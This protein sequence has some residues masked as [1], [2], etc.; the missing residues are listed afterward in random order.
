MAGNKSKSRFTAS[1]KGDTTQKDNGRGQSSTIDTSSNYYSN[2]RAGTNLINT[3]ASTSL[4]KQTMMVGNSISIDVDAISLNASGKTILNGTG[5]HTGNNSQANLP[6]S[7]G[8]KKI[9]KKNQ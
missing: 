1:R 2:G 3:R 7:A 4:E 8:Q 5:M 6:P 9:N